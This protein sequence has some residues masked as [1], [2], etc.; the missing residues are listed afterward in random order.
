[1][2]HGGVS[3]DAILETLRSARVGVFPSFSE[4]FGVAP[5]ECMAQGCPTIYS[6]CSSGPELI[7]DGE[8][9]LLVNPANEKEIA[10]A[11]VRVLGNMDLSRRLGA[12]GRRRVQDFSVGAVTENNVRFYQ[13]CLANWRRSEGP[14]SSSREHFQV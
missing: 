2:F 3:H 6:R 14:I 12:A 5:M 10:Q 13:D 7:T 4:A 8:D 1:V 11:I 9:G